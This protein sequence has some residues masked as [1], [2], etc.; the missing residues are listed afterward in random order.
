MAAKERPQG[1]PVAERGEVREVAPYDAGTIISR[2][3]KGETYRHRFL[4]QFTYHLLKTLD[5]S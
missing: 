3:R 5:H 2:P 4:C 1:H